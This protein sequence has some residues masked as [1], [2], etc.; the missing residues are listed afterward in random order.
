MTKEYLMKA[1]IEE[2]R[3]KKNNALFWTCDRYF[4]SSGF[5]YI[6]KKKSRPISCALHYNRTFETDENIGR[7][8]SNDVMIN[9]REEL[10]FPGLIEYK[11]IWCALASQGNWNETM[12]QFHYNA[13]GSFGPILNKFL[14]TSEE[15]I[16]EKIGVDS[17]PIFMTLPFKGEIPIVPAYFEASSLKRYVMVDVDYEGDVTP[18]KETE[19]RYEQLKVD[20]VKLTF[21]N[22]NTFDAMEFLKQLQD[23]SLSSETNFG[24]L[25]IPGLK[26]K[27]T[28]QISFNWKSLS[29]ESEFRINYCLSADFERKN[30]IMSIKKAFFDMLQAI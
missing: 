14:V 2:F 8:E 22:F 9:T 18:I 6:I 21:V 30:G 12:G 20:R 3:D 11:D 24:L 5:C 16:E 7:F 29:Y 25:D 4:T 27:Q 13:A 15:E 26:A 28:Y 17:M 1:S 23:L 19:K 10:E